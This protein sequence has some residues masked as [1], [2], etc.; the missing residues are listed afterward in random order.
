MKKAVLKGVEMSKSGDKGGAVKFVLKKR[1][2]DAAEFEEAIGKLGKYNYDM[3]VRSTER[4][5]NL[6]TL[7]LI[8]MS[9]VI[10]VSILIGLLLI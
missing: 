3:G 5:E 6:T 1:E 4:G 10:G 2:K 7:T 8:T 9:I